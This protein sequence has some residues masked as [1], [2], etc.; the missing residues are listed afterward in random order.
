MER[1]PKGVAPGSTRFVSA[2]AKD[3]E[4]LPRRCAMCCGSSRERATTSKS[5][6]FRLVV[7]TN[8]EGLG[9]EQPL[10]DTAVTL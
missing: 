7:G 8:T 4:L 10:E 6:K 9:W 3:T 1:V 2:A 5:G